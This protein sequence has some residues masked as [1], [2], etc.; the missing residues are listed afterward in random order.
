MYDTSVMIADGKGR[1]C[2]LWEND[3]IPLLFWNSKHPDLCQFPFSFTITVFVVIHI[4]IIAASQDSCIHAIEWRFSN[5]SE[6][7]KGIENYYKQLK[8][9]SFL[10]VLGVMTLA[11]GST[12]L[13]Y[14]SVV[15]I[16]AIPAITIPVLHRQ[17]LNCMDKGDSEQEWEI[18]KENVMPIKQGRSV[19]S[20]NHALQ[21]DTPQ[22]NRSLQEKVKWEL[23]IQCEW[24]REQEEQ[25]RDYIGS[26]P[27]SPWIS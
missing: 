22:K 6:L 25:I 10:A 11:W 1:L 19:S 23:Q 2:P 7:R 27:L 16:T 21:I 17:S 9:S 14:Q 20:L 15:T 12:K 18:S 26:D 24:R 3:R 5:H 13:P 8:T 4:V